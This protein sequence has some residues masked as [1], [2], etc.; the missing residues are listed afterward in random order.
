MVRA[1]YPWAHFRWA[2]GVRW[3][4]TNTSNSNGRNFQWVPTAFSFSTRYRKFS[5]PPR[6]SPAAGRTAP[7]RLACQSYSTSDFGASQVT[8][9]A[10]PS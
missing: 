7:A 6:K 3:S 9:T 8:A 1:A 10:I 5:T 4:S 2:A